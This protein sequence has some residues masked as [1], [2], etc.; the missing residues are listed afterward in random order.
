M[1]PSIG[2]PSRAFGDE[3]DVWEWNANNVYMRERTENVYMSNFEL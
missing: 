3:S 2:T 1:T